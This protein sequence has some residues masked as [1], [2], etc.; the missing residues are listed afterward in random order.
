M[1]KMR[2]AQV[3]CDITVLRLR[4]LILCIDANYVKLT[5]LS[6]SDS[7]ICPQIYFSKKKVNLHKVI[8]YSIENLKNRCSTVYHKLTKVSVP[9]DRKKL[10]KINEVKKPACK[11]DYFACSM[12]KILKCISF[13]AYFTFSA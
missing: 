7:K 6:P 9:C 10:F 11:D 1:N 4:R 2:W 5:T 12:F 13:C 8:S 3:Q